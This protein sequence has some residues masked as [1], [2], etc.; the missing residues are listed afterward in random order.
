MLEFESSTNSVSN[1]TKKIIGVICVLVFI[2][3][4]VFS[5]LNNEAIVVIWFCVAGIPLGLLG[6]SLL[7]GNAKAGRG[8]LSTTTLYI[9]GSL[10]IVA[11]LFAVLAGQPKA[12]FLLVFAF[13]VF[14][15][16]KKRRNS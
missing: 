3:L 11:V 9:I 1:R 13:A 10:L 4:G 2:T 6:V 16:A 15:L 12:L 5:Y 8:I 7:F 14:A